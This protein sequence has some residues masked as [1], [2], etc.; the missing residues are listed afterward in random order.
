V[1]K[2][3]L[4]GFEGYLQVDG[5]NGYDEICRN[6]EITRIGCM[7][8][9][10]RNF[11]DAYKAG[12]KREGPAYEM[13]LMMKDLYRVEEK[14]KDKSVEERKQTR[15]EESKPMLDKIKA[16]LGSNQN[17]HPPQGLIGK[18][19]GYAQ[20]QWPNLIR[21]LEDGRLAIDN[22]FIE[23]RIR[24]FAIGRKNWLFSDTVAGAKA[25]A[26]IYSILQT[27]RG[28]GL[29]PYAYMRHLLTEL[30]RAQTADQ[31]EKLLPHKIDFK[32]LS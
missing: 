16:W 17:R 3:L 5:Y 9:A 10:R 7:A 15:Q 30:P 19:I 20:N 24:P 25:S 11:F 2:K 26:M 4:E 29:E 8:H 31:I 6:K 12:G 32:I 1:P 22:N 27:A 13:L 23:N 14:I 18:A 28:N 21:Y